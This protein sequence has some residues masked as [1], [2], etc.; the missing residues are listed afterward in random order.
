MS[1]P[2]DCCI[3]LGTQP[4]CLTTQAQWQIW[5][6]HSSR[7][8]Q[9]RKAAHSRHIQ[10][11]RRELCAQIKDMDEP[12]STTRFQ[13]VG[14]GGGDCFYQC[15]VQHENIQNSKSLDT[16]RAVKARILEFA[17][18]R[19]N[20]AAILQGDFS[21]LTAGGNGRTKNT[22]RSSHTSKQTAAMQRSTTCSLQL[23]CFRLTSFWK[24]L[25]IQAPSYRSIARLRGSPP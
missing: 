21:S 14:Q 15:I 7:R 10:P 9:K 4:A 6:G 13:S 3:A 16:N 18:N 22:S 11:P 19:K 17:S 25:L 8:H 2:Q 12:P 20:K 1:H 5:Q 23:W 24:T